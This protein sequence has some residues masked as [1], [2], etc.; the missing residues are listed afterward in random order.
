MGRPE[1]FLNEGNMTLLGGIVSQL[2]LEMPNFDTREQWEDWL[3][4]LVEDHVVQT[5]RYSWTVV[6]NKAQC[7]ADRAWTPEEEENGDD[8]DAFY[9][10]MGNF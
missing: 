10:D 1:D 9:F 6:E 5:S 8:Y 7:L 2:G 3:E 4:Q